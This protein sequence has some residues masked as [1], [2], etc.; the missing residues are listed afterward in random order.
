MKKKAIFNT[1]NIF[2]GRGVNGYGKSH[3]KAFSYSYLLQIVF[4]RILPLPT[5]NYF[6]PYL[7][8]TYLL[9]LSNNKTVAGK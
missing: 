2:L 1:K 5:I 3:V 4:I 7:T 9:W 8:L 6:Y